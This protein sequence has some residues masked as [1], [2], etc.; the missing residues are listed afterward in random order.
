MKVLKVL[1]F[2][3]V[4]LLIAAQVATDI[5][6]FRDAKMN[7]LRDQNS[8]QFVRSL[9]QTQNKDENQMRILRSEIHMLRVTI[10]EMKK[11]ANK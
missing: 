8:E 11:A 4:V 6:V 9:A 5:K 3:L 10:A 1:G 2:V 7:K